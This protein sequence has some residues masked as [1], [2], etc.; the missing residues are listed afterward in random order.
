MPIR[1]GTVDE[2]IAQAQVGDV[3]HFWGKSELSKAI[4]LATHGG[5]S[6]VAMVRNVLQSEKEAGTPAGIITVE[7]TQVS[8]PKRFIGVVN[9]T[10]QTHLDEY[11][12]PGPDFG[13]VVLYC[14]LRPAIR[15]RT[16]WNSWAHNADKH[17]GDP[18]SYG[19]MV[20]EAYDAFMVNHH[21]P[22]L[23]FLAKEFAAGNFHAEFCSQLWCI[24]GQFGEYLSESRIPGLTAP[25]NSLQGAIYG[26]TAIQLTGAPLASDYAYNSVPA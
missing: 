6:H 12:K 21:V 1:Q 9:L 16:D 11:L 19:Q 10:L 24:Y 15:A 2:V 22:G 20:L 13:G 18:Y 3:F 17:V 25:L 5:P 7:S 14:P 23:D 26:P 8:T 4:E